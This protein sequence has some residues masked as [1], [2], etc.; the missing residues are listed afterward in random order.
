M[1]VQEAGKLHDLRVH[2]QRIKTRIARFISQGVRI[3]SLI[4]LYVDLAI[5]QSKL[6]DIINAEVM[7]NMFFSEPAEA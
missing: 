5:T 7:M 4:D 2:H 1:S 3:E 6:D